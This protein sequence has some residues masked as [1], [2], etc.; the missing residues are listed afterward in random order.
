MN[1]KNN[2]MIFIKSI[3]CPNDDFFN[4]ISKSIDNNINYL[5]STSIPI[6]VV[7][8]GWVH[9]SQKKKILNLI[10]FFNYMIHIDY[11]F[12]DDNYGKMKIY[13]YFNNYKS[14]YVFYCDHD[15]F[16]DLSQTKL[17]EIY[18]NLELIFIKNNYDFIAFN[19]KHDCR[20][21][22]SLID[23]IDVINNIK[24]G[25]ASTNN[26]IAG[27]CFIVINQKLC[28]NNKILYGFDEK[29]LF[30][31]LK[32]KKGIFTDNFVIHPYN[33][34]YKH[35]ANWKIDMILKYIDIEVISDNDYKKQIIESHNLW[36]Q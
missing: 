23:N 14:K 11:I 7:L 32:N 28:F 25:S 2:D 36:N 20:H 34:N 1:L 31:N 5:L 29:Y 18:K 35:Y 6:C 15:I 10:K 9:E 19:Q 33:S 27:G 22:L 12:F 16:F 13:E 17:H 8:I 3:F 30:E 4:L 26:F 24:I 21:Q